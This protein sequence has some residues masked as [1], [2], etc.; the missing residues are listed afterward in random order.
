MQREEASGSDSIESS[1]TSFL[2]S[3]ELMRAF[4]RLDN[5]SIMLMDVEPVDFSQPLSLTTARQFI[6]ESFIDLDEARAAFE[7]VFSEFLLG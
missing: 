1:H 6:P 7:S 3:T 4:N 2:G 5:D